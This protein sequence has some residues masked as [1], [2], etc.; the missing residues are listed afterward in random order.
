VVEGRER[1]ERGRS[2]VIMTNHQGDYDILA[3]YGDLRRQ[4]R[5]VKKGGFA[6]A[7]QLGF[8]IL[9]LSIS[10][11][12]RILPKR[13][14]L[15][16]P[17]TIRIRIHPEIDP[18]AFPSDPALIA[19]VRAVIASGLEPDEGGAELVEAP[20]TPASPRR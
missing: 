11:S 1:M 2:Y 4:F 3:L 6:M 19:A 18:A 9:P 15:P 7:R 5:W 16:R 8:P 12:A 10:G 20:A 17:G 13:C 14:L